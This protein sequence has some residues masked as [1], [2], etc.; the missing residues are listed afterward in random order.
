MTH[1]QCLFRSGWSGQAPAAYL[2]DCC[3]WSQ[4]SLR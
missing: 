3:T 2:T 1:W 4:Y